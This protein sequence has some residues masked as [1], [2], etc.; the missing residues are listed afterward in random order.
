MCPLS[1]RRFLILGGAAAAVPSA[2]FG[3]SQDI[4]LQPRARVA[5]LE[6]PRVLKAAEACL[7]IEPKTIVSAIAPRSAGGP[8]DYFS[9]GDYWWPDPKNPDRPYI[10]RDGET[11]PANFIAHRE[12]LIRF[13]IQASALAAAWLLTRRRGFAEHAEAHIRA[14]FTES[15]TRMN[16]NLQFAQAI[17]GI[18]TGRSIGII[19][20]VHLAEVAQAVIVLKKGGVLDESVWR[21]TREWFAAYLDWLTTSAHGQ[22]ERNAK[23]NHGSCW[24]LQ[25]AA[26]ASLTQNNSVRNACRERLRDELFPGQIAADGSFPLELARTKPYSY[27]LFN[28]DVLGMSAHLLSDPADD[29]W[30]HKL[31]D[32]R[33][34]EACFRFMFPYISDRNSWPYRRDVE[35]FDALPVRQPSLLFAAL[36]YGRH[37]YLELWRRLNPDP[38]DQEI[39]RNHPIRQPVLWMYH[40]S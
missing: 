13:S 40:S 9:E 11:N 26:F 22:E 3:S 2:I 12:L 20:T 17:H 6:R 24:L 4:L 21:G 7:K 34:L 36:V 14:W 38:T 18:D 35:H 5:E 32:G 8:H 28:L 23:N 30:T 37:E 31:A 10:R 29:L 33:S 39:I 15:A 1:R 19:D 16:P 25:A 27:S